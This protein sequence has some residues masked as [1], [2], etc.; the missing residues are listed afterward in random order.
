MNKNSSKNRPGASV[1][2]DYTTFGT[3]NDLFQ[4]SRGFW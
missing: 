1:P 3:V 2:Y 4:L